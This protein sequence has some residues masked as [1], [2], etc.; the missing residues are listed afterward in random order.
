MPKTF[1]YVFLSSMIFGQFLFSN[2]NRQKVKTEVRLA[3]EILPAN[4]EFPLSPNAVELELEPSLDMPEIKAPQRIALDAIGRIY[5]SDILKK[6]V[7]V[8]N[9]TGKL[10]C[11]L[12]ESR[13]GKSL[14]EYPW[15]V[16]PSEENT[17][18]QD[19]RK[20]R[21][22][23]FDKNRN[24]ID[25]IRTDEFEDMARNNSGDLY[26]TPLVTDLGQP[27]VSVYSARGKKLSSFGEPLR[28]SHSLTT[29]NR[30]R[31]AL[32]DSGDIYI[33]YQYFPKIR[34]YSADG[35]LQA[36]FA[37]DNNIMKAKETS[38]LKQIGEGI[39]DRN[40]RVGYFKIISAIRFFDG[41]L[42]L[43]SC[44]PRI[45]ILELNLDGKI[46]ITF[47]KDFDEIVTVEDFLVNKVGGRLKFHL[48]LSS[49]FAG[50]D[51]FRPKIS[52]RPVSPVSPKK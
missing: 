52:P 17:W 7:F 27:V 34:K 40:R 23:V 37:I 19:E 6:R 4:G 21:I 20:G 36:E 15:S 24:Q 5:I 11:T 1:R 10:E 26:I 49:P 14:L 35:Q 51:I 30:S 16:S 43:L 44:F 9:P 33:A 32:S 12:G 13:K 38:N 29:L 47:W 2:G 22:I 46:S 25:S 45:E 31:L 3:T 18:V 41:R 50:V 39:A 28:F 48:I 8:Y 42:Y